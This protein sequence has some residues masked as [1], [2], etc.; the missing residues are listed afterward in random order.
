MSQ[1]DSHACEN[2]CKILIG[3]KND[4][5]REREV[6]EEEGRNLAASKKMHFAEVSAKSGYNVTE[7]FEK[8]ARMMK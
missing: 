7:V 6:T 8:M 4:L 2:V 5:A 1:I 3:T